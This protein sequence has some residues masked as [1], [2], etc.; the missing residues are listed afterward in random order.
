[1][2]AFAFRVT[3]WLFL[4]AAL[5]LWLGWSLLPVRPAAFFT[6]RV[7]GEIRAVYRRWIWIYRVHIFGYLGI[8]MASAAL[9]AGVERA[10][11]RPLL[12]PGLAV[13]AVGALVG[14]LG[15]AFYYHM[16]AWGAVDLDGRGEDEA[17][18]FVAGLRPLTHYATCLVRFGR[19]FFGV[20]QLVLAAGLLR[21]GIVPSGLAWAAGGLGAAAIAVTMAKPDE[22]ERYRPI[23]HLNAAWMLLLGVA[24]IRA[25]HGG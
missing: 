9:A 5:M 22:L 23:F 3:G 25:G 10:D 21:A 13:L 14:A 12:W 11:A 18:R 15:S 16:G 8:V 4:G 6:P 19:V 7:F 20:G 2:T 17:Q 1:M 24:A